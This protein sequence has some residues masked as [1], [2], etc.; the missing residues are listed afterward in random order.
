MSTA[1]T[2]ARSTRAQHFNPRTAELASDAKRAEQDAAIAHVE[3]LLRQH[4]HRRLLER[5]AADTALSGLPPTRRGWIVLYV[6]TWLAA[7]AASA[8]WPWGF[9]S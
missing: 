7:L 2:S 4:R 5:V 1:Q 8:W 3:E 6:A 9:A